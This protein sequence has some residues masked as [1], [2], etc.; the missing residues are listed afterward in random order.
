MAKLD[1]ADALR[2]AQAKRRTEEAAAAVAAAAAKIQSSSRST[3]YANHPKLSLASSGPSEVQVR[4]KKPKAPERTIPCP[5]CGQVPYHIMK[6]CPK[7]QTS[8]S[9]KQLLD[10]F[11]TGRLTDYGTG[12][13]PLLK[14]ML[15]QRNGGALT[16][17]QPGPSSSAAPQVSG[18]KY[19]AFGTSS[20]QL[21]RYPG[22]Q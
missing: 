3:G 18:P 14:R 2:R 11:K 19:K 21:D 5:L 22:A 8:A 13:V 7:T 4:Q 16:L 6:R 20:F 9:I 15:K 12:T 1:A 10:D 17:N